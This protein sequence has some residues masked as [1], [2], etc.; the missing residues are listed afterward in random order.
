MSLG[1]FSLDIFS[2]IFP[3]DF[4]LSDFSHYDIPQGLS[5][6]IYT[7]R[8]FLPHVYECVNDSKYI[9]ETM[10]VYENVQ[11][12]Y[13]TFHLCSLCLAKNYFI[14]P[15]SIWNTFIHKSNFY[16]ANLNNTASI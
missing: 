3:Y 7:P 10:D 9:Y 4:S 12:I 2:R 16:L 5:L 15:P 11:F 6:K 14:N 1:L 13:P 8:T